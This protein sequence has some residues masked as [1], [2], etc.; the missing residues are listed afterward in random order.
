MP[1]DDPALR[2]PAMWQDRRD[3][4]VQA[5]LTALVMSGGG[6]DWLSMQRALAAAFTEAARQEMDRHGAGPAWASL[7]RTAA[8]LSAP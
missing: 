6:A 3:A 5:A 1:P 7:S 8:R 4:I 2:D